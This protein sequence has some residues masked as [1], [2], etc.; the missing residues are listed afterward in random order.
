MKRKSEECGSNNS[1]AKNQTKGSSG[2]EQDS[3]QPSNLNPVSETG[4]ES[5]GDEPVASGNNGSVENE[6]VSEMAPVSISI[7]TDYAAAACEFGVAV[8]GP[9]SAAAASQVGVVAVSPG[10]AAA[11]SN[12]ANSSSV[13]TGSNLEAVDKQT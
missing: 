11:T 8:V 12:S 13:A 6:N 2:N 10:G 5:Q 3:G 4:S 7:G 9:N 1:N